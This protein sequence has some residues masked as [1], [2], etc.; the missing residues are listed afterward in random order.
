[1]N[2]AEIP[3]AGVAW[4]KGLSPH[5]ARE[6]LASVYAAIA[7]KPAANILQTQSLDPEGLRHHYALYKHLMYGAAKISRFSAR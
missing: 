4:D 1:M 7:G 6:P 2:E 3:S 5:D